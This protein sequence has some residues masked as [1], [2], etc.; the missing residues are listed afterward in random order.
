MAKEFV[1]VSRVD[2][3]ADVKLPNMVNGVFH[4]FAAK[5]VVVE[6][7]EVA[8]VDTGAKVTIPPGY[9]GQLLAPRGFTTSKG[10]DLVEAYAIRGT[11]REV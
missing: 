10:M 1:F 6:P 4:V 7:G 5:K 11:L 9:M 2:Q 8:T 3:N